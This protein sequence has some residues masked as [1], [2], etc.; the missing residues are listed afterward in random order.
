MDEGLGH[1]R[2]AIDDLARRLQREYLYLPPDDFTESDAR[3][4]EAV[5]AY[6]ACSAVMDRVS[7]IMKANDRLHGREGSA[8]E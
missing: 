4:L 2:G 3:L 1:P 7:D 8:A 6:P 5:Q